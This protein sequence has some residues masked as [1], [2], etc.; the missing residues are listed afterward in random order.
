MPIHLNPHTV[1]EFEDW[2]IDAFERAM[3]YRAICGR[4]L[5]SFLTSL[6]LHF[7]REPFIM[8][9]NRYRYIRY[10]QT[11]KIRLEA[12]PL[13]HAERAGQS[14]RATFPAQSRTPDKIDMQIVRPALS[15]AISICPIQTPD[16]AP[17]GRRHVSAGSVANPSPI[18][19]HRDAVAR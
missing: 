4:K 10:M 13:N 1:Q 14:T 9:F 5:Q 6:I 17:R 8:N 11:S 19:P 18:A 2:E 7:K 12:R 16:W 3:H 15:P